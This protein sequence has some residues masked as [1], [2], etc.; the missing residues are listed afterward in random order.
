MLQCNDAAS[1]CD[2]PKTIP[3]AACWTWIKKDSAKRKLSQ[4]NPAQRHPSFRLTMRTHTHI[5]NVWGGGVKENDRDHLTMSSTFRCA[6]LYRACEDCWEGDRL[7]MW[8]VVCWWTRR[9]W[10]GAR[11]AFVQDGIT[12]VYTG[13]WVV[14]G[15]WSCSDL[16]WLEYTPNRFKEKSSTQ[17]HPSRHLERESEPKV[18]N[19]HK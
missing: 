11:V 16:M 17:H 7:I 2:S 1:G 10:G 18:S 14:K 19:E 8:L 13:H 3:R 9:G 12:R 5:Y 4:K 15:C 6:Q